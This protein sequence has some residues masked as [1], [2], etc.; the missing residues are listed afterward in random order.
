MRSIFYYSWYQT[1][2]RA[3]SAQVSLISVYE[4]VTC[5]SRKLPSGETPFLERDQQIGGPGK[6]V[7][8]DESKFGKRK[9]HRGHRV[10]GQ[11][12]FGGIE[13]GLG[14]VLWQL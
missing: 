14:V 10:E 8:I 5:P 2:N 12:V 9:C 3:S 11:W 6:I 13:E 7:Q 4:E 1:S